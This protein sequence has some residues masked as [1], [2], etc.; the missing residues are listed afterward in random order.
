[1]NSHTDPEF[2][3]R[4]AKL[5]PEV[6]RQAMTAFQQ[7][8]RDPSHRS[9]Q[10]KLLNRRLGLYS[11]RVGAGY[12]ALAIKDRDQVNWIWIGSH[13]EYDHLDFNS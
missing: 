9:L 7:F 3:E 8:K 6:Q 2:R 12:R 1:M 13:A 4:L 5:P 10:F 11:A